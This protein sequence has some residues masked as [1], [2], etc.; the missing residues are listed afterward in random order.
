MSILSFSRNNCLRYFLLRV[1]ILFTVLFCLACSTPQTS[2]YKRYNSYS[3]EINQH[4]RLINASPE[5]IFGILTD[6]VQYTSLAPAYTHIAFYTPPPYRK[7]SRFKIDIDHLLNFSWYSEVQEVVS[8]RKT[9]LTFLDGLF[10]G[11][12]EIWELVPKNDKTLV[13]QTI[14]VSPEGWFHTFIWNFKARK[15]HDVI[16]ETLLDNLKQHAE[17]S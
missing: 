1:L 11:G 13:I 14:I 7:G 17:K 3:G 5:K 4:S 16:I 6:P 9:R 8:N 2:V 10:K 15:R 12:A